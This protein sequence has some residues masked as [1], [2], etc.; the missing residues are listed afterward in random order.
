MEIEL[1]KYT[2]TERKDLLG[3]FNIRVEMTGY[4]VNEDKTIE[5]TQSEKE[6][7]VWG[8]A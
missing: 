6:K 5:L 2:V 8:V 7:I 4:S 3:S 1:K